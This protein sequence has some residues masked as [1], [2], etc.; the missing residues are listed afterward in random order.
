M[1]VDPEDPERDE[2]EMAPDAMLA[3]ARRA[4]ELVVDRLEGLR[5]EPAWRGGTRQELEPLMRENMLEPLM[6]FVI[7]PEV[8][9]PR[10]WWGGSAVSKPRLTHP[11]SS[12]RV[13]PSSRPPEWIRCSGAPPRPPR[14]VTDARTRWAATRMCG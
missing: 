14:P 10:Q 9:D 2:L 5:N 1:S 8:K 4:A 11:A 13:L 3:L 6:D 7:L 12:M